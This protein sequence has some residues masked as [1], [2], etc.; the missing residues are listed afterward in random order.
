M[1]AKVK[2]GFPPPFYRGKD[3]KKQEPTLKRAIWGQQ[4]FSKRSKQKFQGRALQ[5]VDKK[6]WNERANGRARRWEK[7]KWEK[8]THIRNYGDTNIVDC[9]FKTKMTNHIIIYIWWGYSKLTLFY[10]TFCLTQVIPLLKKK[11][12][13]YRTE[14]SIHYL[15]VTYVTLAFKINYY[16]KVTV[17]KVKVIKN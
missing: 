13:D 10:Q 12:T 11:I 14:K 15:L 17:N 9:I 7:H 5:K 8:W 16:I 2:Q 6:E 4:M 3:F 1:N